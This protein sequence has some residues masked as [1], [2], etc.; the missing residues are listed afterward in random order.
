MFGQLP[1]DMK[2]F[3]VFVPTLS[4]QDRD[5]HKEAVLSCDYCNAFMW[6]IDDDDDIPFS[7]LEDSGIFHLVL[8]QQPTTLPLPSV[9][10]LLSAF[11]EVTGSC[12]QEQP[13]KTDRETSC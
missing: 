3:P 9:A 5:F 2:M 6:D 11:P 7:S 1:P 4:N 10:L 13:P 8:V 12:F